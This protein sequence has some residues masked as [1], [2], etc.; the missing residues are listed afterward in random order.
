MST[1]SKRA[2]DDTLRI[3]RMLRQA[4]QPVTTRQIADK[5][6]IN[7]NRVRELMHVVQDRN[8][9]R[10]QQRYLGKLM[11]YCIGDKFP[12]QERIFTLPDDLWRGWRNPVTGYQPDRLGP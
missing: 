11:H 10:W 12:T 4:K 7:V 8:E 6:G 2:S 5:T 9:A 1:P 3:E